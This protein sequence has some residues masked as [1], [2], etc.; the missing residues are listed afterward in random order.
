MEPVTPQFRFSCIGMFADVR[1]ALRMMRR[2]PGFTAVAIAAPALGIGANDAI[3]TVVNSVLLQPLPFPEPD[4]L[5]QLG[6]QSPNNEDGFSNSIPEYMVWRQSKAFEAMTI[7]GW[8]G[9][10]MNLG[11][12]DRPEHV[13][14]L[15]ASADYFRVFGASPLIGRGYT[16]A[17][18]IPGGPKLV[19]IGVLR[20]GFQPDPPADVVLPIQA[21]PNSA[22]QGHYLRIA[23]RL[24]PGVTVEAPRAEMKV[25]GERFR[26]L[27]PKFMDKNESVAVVPMREA[28]VGGVKPALLTRTM[29]QVISESVAREHFNMVLLTSAPNRSRRSRRRY[30]SLKELSTASTGIT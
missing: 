21:D 28:T 24:K 23:A 5:M 18:D 12:S 16:P 22:N 3:F 11:S 13:K 10:G 8:G 14:S 2:N 25:V 30:Q 4:R 29:E 20:E 1:Y 27:Y 17:E 9:P 6:R 26:A 7:C 19:V 15:Q